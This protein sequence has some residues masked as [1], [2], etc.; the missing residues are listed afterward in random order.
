MRSNLTFGVPHDLILGL[1][2]VKTCTKYSSKHSK[3]CGVIVST[4]S[5]SGMS[6]GAKIVCGG[7]PNCDMKF[8]LTSWSK[9]VLKYRELQSIVRFV[10]FVSILLGDMVK[11][12]IMFEA[13]MVSRI[14]Q[15]NKMVEIDAYLLLTHRVAEVIHLELLTKRRKAK[16]MYRASHASWV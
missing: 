7:L 6:F 3:S 4:K 16:C 8:F 1:L 15:R 14:V 9:L 2:L 10:T 12:I 13:E 5:G 11:F